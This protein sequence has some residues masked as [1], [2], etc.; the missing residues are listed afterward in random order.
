MLRT[1]LALFKKLSHSKLKQESLRKKK[2][3]SILLIFFYMYSC[4]VLSCLP[5]SFSRKGKY[6]IV[7]IISVT[8]FTLT[9]F[10]K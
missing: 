2:Y 7:N 9:M 8:V 6:F 3:Q 4:L 10:K 5:S 1:F